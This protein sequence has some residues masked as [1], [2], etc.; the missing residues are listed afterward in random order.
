MTSS[1]SSTTGK[2][3][4]SFPKSTRIWVFA[5]DPAALGAGKT[6]IIRP[7][8]MMMRLLSEARV[9]TIKEAGMIK[10]K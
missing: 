7:V 9:T 8:L 1:N 2:E 10:F 6:L 4:F 5:F 3:E